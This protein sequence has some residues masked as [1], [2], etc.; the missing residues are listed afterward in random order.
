MD[1]ELSGGIYSYSRLGGEECERFP[2]MW[3]PP[4]LVQASFEGSWCGVAILTV[5]DM[6]AF[7][8]IL[9]YIANT[10]MLKTTDFGSLDK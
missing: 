8:E 7:V 1:A 4:Y 3:V 9:R 2:E 10:C 5:W 6:A